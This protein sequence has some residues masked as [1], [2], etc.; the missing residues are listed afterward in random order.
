M[1]FTTSQ[2]KWCEALDVKAGMYVNQL[3][4]EWPFRMFEVKD[5]FL[6]LLINHHTYL[7]FRDSKVVKL[8]KCK[9]VNGYYYQTINI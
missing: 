8:A 1:K 7:N 2:N 6:Y 9:G 5:G 3:I 4:A